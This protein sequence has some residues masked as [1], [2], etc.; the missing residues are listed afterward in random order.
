MFGCTVCV[1]VWVCGVGWAAEENIYPMDL[2]TSLLPQTG[3]QVPPKTTPNIFSVTNNAILT[4]KHP[5]GVTSIQSYV[6]FLS[7]KMDA[8][9]ALLFENLN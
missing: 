6:D 9:C 3:Y 8:V 7:Y 4:R 2:T 5:I 1:C